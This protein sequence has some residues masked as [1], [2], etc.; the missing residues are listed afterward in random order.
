MLMEMSESSVDQ[1]LPAPIS[2][3]LLDVDAMVR[4]PRR[5]HFIRAAMVGL[6]AGLLAVAFRRLLALAESERG[7]LLDLLHGYPSWGW[8][9][10]PVI[11]GCVGGLVGWMTTRF[12]PEASGSGIPHLKGVLIHVRTLEWRRLIPVKF[13]GGILGIGAGLSLGREGPTVQMGAA[14]AKAFA[15]VL[16]TPESDLPQLL[17]AGAGA[18]LAAAFNAPL[19]G[20]L[21]VVEELH[22]DLSSRI[23]AGALIAAVCA[24]VIT[25]WLAGDTPSFEAHGLG[26]VPLST[27]PLVLIVGLLGGGAGVLFNK[28]LLGAQHFAQRQRRVPRWMLPAIAGLVAGMLGWVMPDAIGGGQ[29]FAERIL[30]GTIN[31]GAAALAALF[32]VKLA[33]T[34]LSY[35][36]GAPGGIFAPMLVLGALLGALFGKATVAIL[37]AQAGQAQVLAVLGMAAVF[38]GSV[39]APLT[40]IVLISEMTGGYTLLFPICIASLS[41]YLIAEGLRDLPI[42]DALLEADLE[43][44]GHGPSQIE[45]RSMYIG[46][47]LGSAVANK[48]VAGAGLPRGCLIIAIERGGGNL[49]PTADTVVHAGD[50]LRILTPGDQP[51]ATMDIVRL[52]TGL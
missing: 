8:A 4:P 45:P 26:A 31:A 19:A 15:G 1:A 16:R 52:C 10:L 35:G 50:H 42:Y 28:S 21:F 36:S 48:R 38:A 20:L 27:L 7:R 3:S 9:V 2:D 47:Q 51:Q 6:L 11:G 12:A 17:S 32:F 24:T 14:V 43:R 29:V 37:P 13:F 23:A 5:Y 49:L 33:F 46:V 18:G 41:A 39:R 44:S 30:G 25:Q 34:A 40:G 22:R